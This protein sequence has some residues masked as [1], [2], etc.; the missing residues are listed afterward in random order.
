MIG[1]SVNRDGVPKR[2]SGSKMFLGRELLID[3][4]DDF[5]SDLFGMTAPKSFGNSCSK[6]P[7]REAFKNRF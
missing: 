2:L 5:L 1:A 4:I 7:A 6:K 3:Q